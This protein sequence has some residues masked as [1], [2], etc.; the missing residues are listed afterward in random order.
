MSRKIQTPRSSSRAV[1]SPSEANAS[2]AAATPAVD[3][4]S[5]AKRDSWLTLSTARRRGAALVE[6]SLVFLLFVV[7]L[8]AMIEF[9]RGMWTYATI[10]HAAR[11]GGRYCMVR[12]SFNPTSL[13]A[14]KTAV[15]KHCI[16]LDA[17]QIGVTATWNGGADPT[18]IERGDF[19]EVEVTYP[20]QF[21][22]AGLLL[23]GSNSIA[24]SSKTRMVL[25]N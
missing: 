3:N 20:F 7:V 22:A 19:V 2:P 24:M 11:Q 14:V 16:G 17:S 10:A 9:G 18:A 23:E 1:I 25:L 13:T 5:A 4:G 15:K 6:F 8:V 21:A 12:G